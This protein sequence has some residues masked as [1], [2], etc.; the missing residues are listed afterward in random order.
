MLRRREGGI[1]DVD[2]DMSCRFL[3]KKLKFLFCERFFVLYNMYT[4]INIYILGQS[5]K[6]D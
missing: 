2:K 5:S 6:C 3:L 1:L 4:A